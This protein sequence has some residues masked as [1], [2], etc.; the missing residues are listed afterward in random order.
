MC[1]SCQDQSEHNIT[2]TG[3][4]IESIDYCSVTHC[5]LDAAGCVQPCRITRTNPIDL[6]KKKQNLIENSTVLLKLQHWANPCAMSFSNLMV[7]LSFTIVCNSADFY[8]INE[9]RWNLTI[10]SSRQPEIGQCS[11]KCLA[12]S[13]THSP[14]LSVHLVQMISQCVPTR[15]SIPSVHLRPIPTPKVLK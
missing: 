9:A 13:G 1:V 15:Y 3:Q 2:K 4:R 5:R 12:V 10:S 14:L 6:N 11:R 8:L 7:P